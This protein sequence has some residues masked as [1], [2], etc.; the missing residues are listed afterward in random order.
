MKTKITIVFLCL[1][2]M[3]F[4]K[5]AIW[6]GTADVSWYK[7]KDTLYKISTAQQLAGLAQLVN[8]GADFAGKTVRLVSDIWLN[9]TSGWKNWDATAPKNE[10]TPIGHFKKGPYFNIRS[11]FNG[12][13]DGNG[14]VIYGMYI[15]YAVSPVLLYNSQGLFG[16]IYGAKITNLAISNFYVSSRNFYTGSIVGFSEESVINKCSLKGKIDANAFVGGISG[17][18][19]NL[20]ISENSVSVDVSSKQGGGG[21]AGIIQNTQVSKN[22]FAGIVSGKRN[23]IGILVA[24]ASGKSS[25]IDNSF[26]NKDDIKVVGKYGKSVTVNN[27]NRI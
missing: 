11:F 26:S 2:G 19:K 24:K 9:D 23:R 20:S 7:E 8:D 3:I 18:C 25:V 16:A 6:N 27:N 4:A 13:F 15:N 17:Q 22:K 12:T 5:P 10:W 1:C 14:K 21:I